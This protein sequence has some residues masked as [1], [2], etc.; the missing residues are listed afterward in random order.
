MHLADAQLS[1]LHVWKESVSA[2]VLDASQR[3]QQ[4]RARQ[5]G[6]RSPTPATACQLAND[7]AISRQSVSWNC[8]SSPPTQRA[9]VRGSTS[10][11]FQISHAALTTPGGGGGA[12][13]GSK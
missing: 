12:T 13:V 9:S 1:D 2:P 7:R 10:A 4:L 5:R 8:P 6:A 3:L 11:R